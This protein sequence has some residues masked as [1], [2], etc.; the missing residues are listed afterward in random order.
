M[1]KPNS[2]LIVF[3][4]PP[5]RVPKIL[6]EEVGRMFPRKN[7]PLITGT[8][9]LTLPQDQDPLSALIHAWHMPQGL[10]RTFMHDVPKALA[11]CELV[12]VEALGLSVFAEIAHNLPADAP[13]REETLSRLLVVH[14][15][16]VQAYMQEAKIAAKIVYLVFGTRAKSEAYYN[17]YLGV[18][19]QKMHRVP[20]HESD[21]DIA[22]FAAAVIGDIAHEHG[23]H[24]NTSRL[25]VAA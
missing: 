12:L 6:H 21:L 1:P 5:P 16:L 2:V 20:S 4:A 17:Q 22:R 15:A 11:Q 13:D 25:H 18:L 23:I 3:K 19:G 9:Y 10:G 7:I 14:Q 8:R 24:N